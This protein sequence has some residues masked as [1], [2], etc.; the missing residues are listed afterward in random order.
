M[1]P[2]RLLHV[3]LP[4]LAVAACDRGEPGSAPPPPEQVDVEASAAVEG[5]SVSLHPAILRSTDEAAIT[6]RTSGTVVSMR[7]DVGSRVAAGDTLVEL[8]S[9]DVRARIEGAEAEVDRARQRFE[10]IRNL[11]RDG[12]ATGQELDDARAGLLGAE[13]RLREA[14]AQLEYVVLQAPFSG[15][16]TARMADAG[17]LAVPGRPILR[18]VRPGALEVAADLP[19]GVG[20]GVAEG[21]RFVVRDPETGAVREARVIRV[22]PAQDPSSRRTRVELR[23]AG[24]GG[25]GAAGFVP[26]SYAR[27]EREAP[28]TSTVWIPADAVIRRGQLAG[29]FTLDG[30]ALDLR[31]VRLGLRRG[32][33]V[34]VLTGI[35]PGQLVVRRPGNDLAD[36]VAVGSIREVP[37]SREEGS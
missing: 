16:V 12:A 9:D 25:E 15:T 37:W 29:V 5:P 23:F 3:L 27:L 34:E 6:T 32:A 35:E 36:G 8:Q 13:A 31:W 22:S 1:T 33:T 19:A 11:E 28:G 26:G 7:A 21:D 14:R 20:R 4:V 2:R 24:D 10:R 30:E 17:D 18:L